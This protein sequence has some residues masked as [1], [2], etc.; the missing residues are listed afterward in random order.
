MSEKVFDVAVIGGGVV[1]AAVAR[2]VARRDCSVIIIDEKN[3]F[4]AGTS[5][6]NTAILHTGFDTTPG[7]NESRIVRRGYELLFEYATNSGIAVEQT[8]AVMV[9]WNDEQ[10]QQLEPVAKKSIK[11]GH[12]KIERISNSELKK[13]EPNL[14]AA[15]LGGLLVRGEY[16]IDPWSVPLAFARDALKFGAEVK[17]ET[18]VKSIEV[19]DE[20]TTLV[21]ATEKIKT[22]YVVNCAGL[23]GAKVDELFSGRRFTVKPRRGELIVFDKMARG[24]I[25]RIILPV[26][27]KHTKGV[28]VAPTVFGNLMVG[29]TADDVDDDTTTGSTQVG[30]ARVLAAAYR[31][32]PQLENEE[33]TAVYAGLRAATE[34]SDYR[35][36][37]D[38]DTRYVCIGGIR[39]TGLTAS[40]ALAEEACTRLTAC[41]LELATKSGN[42]VYVTMPPLG[43]KQHRPADNGIAC[44]CLCERVTADE[45]TNACTSSPA[46]KDL[47]GVRRRTRA[48][49]GKCQGFYCLAEVCALTARATEKSVE[50]LLKTT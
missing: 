15:T 14:A 23:G 18:S 48:L 49:N 50:T 12:D 46:A 25:E 8:D 45:I 2:E 24:L 42:N 3:D 11:N 30:L 26:P 31:M 47:D 29:P 5:K 32:V 41:G 39:S 7:S 4:G 21:T 13:L 22:R 28:L 10:L 19:S 37:T 34:E 16:I 20:F 6:A 27:Q 43:E 35:L 9:A 38:G 44:V 17:L 1:G 36:Y 40:M 33:I